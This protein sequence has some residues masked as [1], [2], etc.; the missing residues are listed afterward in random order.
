MKAVVFRGIGDV[1]T[2]ATIRIIS[3]AICGTDLHMA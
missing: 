1:P 3:S 2:D